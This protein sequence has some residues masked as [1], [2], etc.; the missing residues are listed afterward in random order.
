[1]EQAQTEYAAAMDSALKS[2]TETVQET[3]R[4]TIKDTPVEVV[5]QVERHKAEQEK[6]SVEDE[7]RDHLRGFSRTI[8]SFIMSYGDGDLILANFDTKTDAGVF[9]EVTG[10]TI[11]D[12]R[13]LRD[14]GEYTDPETGESTRFAGHLFDEVVFNDSVEEF[15]KKTAVGRLLR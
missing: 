8:P 10:I 9:Q 3:V 5:E 2:F 6:K 14:G 1:M 15:W 4:Q 13:F 12:F 7:V 11:E